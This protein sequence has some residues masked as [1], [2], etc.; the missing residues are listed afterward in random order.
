VI[1]TLPNCITAE[2]PDLGAEPITA[3]DLLMQRLREIKLA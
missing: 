3:Q 1:E 2:H